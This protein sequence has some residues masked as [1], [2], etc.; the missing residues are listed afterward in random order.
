[1]RVLVGY[2]TAHGS[3]REIAE[4]VGARLERYGLEV[5]VREL[6]RVAA[7][8][9]FDAFVLAS[10]VHGQRWLPEARAFVA[11]H[12]PELA[13]K[14]VWL[15][16]VGMPDALRCPWRLLASLQPPLLVEELADRVSF[17][18]HLVV[19]GVIRDDH[20]PLFGWLALLALT[21]GAGDY[22]D[23]DR[24]DAWADG[25][26]RVLTTLP[27]PTG[28]RRRASSGARA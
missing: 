20:L 12:A 6:A 13:A 15:L 9:A 4:H 25:V 5:D 18:D 11:E 3:T 24:I 2:A 27:A 17:R 10:A 14:P 28:R 26:G 22:R 21:R 7:P 1:M 19:S 23:W 8:A 16:S